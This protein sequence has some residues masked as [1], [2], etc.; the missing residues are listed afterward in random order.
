MQIEEITKFRSSDNLIFGSHCDSNTKE[1]KYK[2]V[3]KG[4]QKV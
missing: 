2:H 1:D 4:K 3:Y